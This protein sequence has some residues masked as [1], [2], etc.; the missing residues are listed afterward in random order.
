MVSEPAKWIDDFAKAGAS[1]ITFHVESNLE[2]DSS[3]NNS[4]NSPDAIAQVCRQIRA[5]GMRAALSIK[6]KTSVQIVLDVLAAHREL[7][8]MVLIMSVEPGFGGQEFM[9]EQ[10]DKV[11][12]LREKYPDLDIQVDGGVSPSTIEK[13]AQAGANI[14][15]A[16]SAIFGH[17]NPTEIIAALRKPIDEKIA[18]K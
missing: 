10:M 12:I 7:V 4:T 3:T 9:P 18:T 11:R 6:P 17:K 14:V 5:K 15:V 1:S 2:S 16:G 8:D 13:V